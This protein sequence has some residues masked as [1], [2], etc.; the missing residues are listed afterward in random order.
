METKQNF[1]KSNSVLL[2]II[3]YLTG[4]LFLILTH[5]ID[6]TNLAG[7]G[8]DIIGFLVY[9]GV[10]IWLSGKTLVGIFRF[11]SAKESVTDI[12]L[13]LLINLCGIASLIIL[14]I[15]PANSW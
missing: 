12:I 10:N 15:I 5:Y 13:S 9:L 14:C 8:L 11:T 2:L 4:L 7:P 1:W 6:P 3:Y